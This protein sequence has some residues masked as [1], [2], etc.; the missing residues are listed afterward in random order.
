MKKIIILT[1][2]IGSILAFLIFK[3]TYHEE[4]NILSL[5][6]GLALGET[7]FNVRGYSFNDYLKDYY[8]ENTNLKE[9]ITEFASKRETTSSLLLKIT[10]NYTLES[11]N[12]SITQAIAKAQVLTL[13]IGMDE[14]NL[15]EEI[16]SP[17]IAKYLANIEKIIQLI[18]YKIGHPESKSFSLFSVEKDGKLS[19][20]DSQ[21]FIPSQTNNF[22][23]FYFK[24]RCFILSFDDI[25]NR[26]ARRQVV[27]DCRDYILNNKTSIR[28]KILMINIY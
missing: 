17:I 18:L 12:I 10:T 3:V 5:G 28:I 23:E 25:T 8:E 22:T 24:R 6:D 15:E 4:I 2:L 7:A 26:I 19:P 11:P 13:A 21:Y 20:M 27:N 14:L 9:Y 1:V 16:T